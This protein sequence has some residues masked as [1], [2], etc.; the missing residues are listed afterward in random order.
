MSKDDNTTF[1]KVLSDTMNVVAD[2]TLIQ[3][4]YNTFRFGNDILDIMSNKGAQIPLMLIP[5]IVKV[6]IPIFQTWGVTYSNGVRGVVEK[7]F[8][9]IWPYGLSSGTDIYTGDRVARYG[10]STNVSH[11]SS[12]F[13]QIVNKFLPLTI[14]PNIYTKLQRE[15]IALGI[16]KSELNGRYNEKQLIASQKR[17]LNQYYGRLNNSTL[18]ELMANKVKYTVKD[19]KGKEISL[20]YNKMSDKQKKDV[21]TRI[22]SNNAQTAKIWYFTENEGYKYYTSESE[23]QRLKKLGIKNVYKKDSKRDGLIK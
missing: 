5:N 13:A 20:T 22:M 1:W 11:W 23:Y 12:F 17:K 6:M 15:A 4:F 18:T 2:N 21:I 3:D 8:G 7:Y 9:K 14:T 19:D 16:N 10:G